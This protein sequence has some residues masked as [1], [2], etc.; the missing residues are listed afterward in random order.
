MSSSITQF[1]FGLSRGSLN[2]HFRITLAIEDVQK[3]LGATAISSS[4]SSSS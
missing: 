2:Q 3:F 1:K 4:S